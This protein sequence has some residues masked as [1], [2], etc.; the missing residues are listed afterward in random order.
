MIGTGALAV[1]VAQLV[2]PDVAMDGAGGLTI[3]PTT[4]VAATIALDGV[5][6]L[7]VTGAAFG[8]F[9]VARHPGATLTSTDRRATLVGTGPG[10]LYV[11]GDDL[12]EFPPLVVSQ[13]GATIATHHGEAHL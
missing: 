8:Q 9:V 7:T 5:G 11:F 6:L 1:S 2:L 10:V 4:V 12:G 13:A 3:A